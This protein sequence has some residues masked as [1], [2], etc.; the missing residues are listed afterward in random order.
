MH[1]VNRGP[2]SKVKSTLVV[3][4]ELMFTILAA[5]AVVD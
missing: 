5:H 2:V 4:I 1:F 3:V